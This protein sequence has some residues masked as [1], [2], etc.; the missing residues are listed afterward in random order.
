MEEGVFTQFILV[1]NWPVKGQHSYWHPDWLVDTEP[2]RINL[3]RMYK[4]AP[5]MDAKI[6]IFTFLKVILLILTV[7]D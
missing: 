2:I 5:V 7:I 3:R 6:E 1:K 4:G